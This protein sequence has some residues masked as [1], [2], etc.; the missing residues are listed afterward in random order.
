MQPVSEPTC[1]HCGK[2]REDHYPSNES[3]DVCEVTPIFT[4]GPTRATL[5]ADLNRMRIGR[6]ASSLSTNADDEALI[7]A[8]ASRALKPSDGK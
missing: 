2:T 1:A 7:S 6:A 3:R 4:P 5:K 8:A